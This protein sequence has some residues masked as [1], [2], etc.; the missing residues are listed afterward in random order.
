[1]WYGCITLYITSVILENVISVLNGALW[2]MKQVHFGICAIGLLGEL[3]VDIMHLIRD[4]FTGTE[5]IQV[6]MIARVQLK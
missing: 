4:H 1:M 2:D 3:T 6:F 5:T